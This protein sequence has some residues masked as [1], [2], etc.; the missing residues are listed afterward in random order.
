MRDHLLWGSRETTEILLKCLVYHIM[1][2]C[3]ILHY[4]IDTNFKMKFKFFYLSPH[5]LRPSSLLDHYHVL[6]VSL[7]P[8][9]FSPKP[10]STQWPWGFLQKNYRKSLLWKLFSDFSSCVQER[11]CKRLPILLPRR[12]CRQEATFMAQASDSSIW[13]AEARGEARETKDSIFNS[14]RVISKVC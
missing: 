8:L 1:S 13:K 6:L 7:P 11:K 14:H 10:W 9:L 12:L 4:F 5:I 2:P 3:D